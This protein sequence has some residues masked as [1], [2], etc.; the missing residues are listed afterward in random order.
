MIDK[1]ILLGMTNRHIDQETGLHH[2]IL[3]PL[4]KLKE[5]L[6]EKTFELSV[7]SGF[8][9]FHRQKIIW[10]EKASGKRDILDHLGKKIDFNSLKP[11]ELLFNILRWSAI[12]GTSRH[13][14]GTDFDIIDTSNLTDNYVVKLIPE[15]SAPSGIFY[16]FHK[17]IDLL[18]KNNNAFDF[19]RPY[20]KDLGGVSPEKW[21]ISF[22]PLSEQFMKEYSFTFFINFLDSQNQNDFLLLDLIKENAVEIYENY[23]INISLG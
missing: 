13:H 20:E 6:K 16:D 1:N 3:E 19:F 12:P 15:E 8:R 18:I 2:D 7:I 9:N 21:H 17:E 5:K 4:L 14:W 23:I 22:R 11:K 10:N